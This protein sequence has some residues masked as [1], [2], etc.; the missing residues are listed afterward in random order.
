MRIQRKQRKQ[1][2]NDRVFSA[3]NDAQPDRREAVENELRLPYQERIRLKKFSSTEE[4]KES[5]GRDEFSVWDFE[6]WHN[7]WQVYGS[8]EFDE[9]EMH[10]C[11]LCSRNKMER[12]FCELAD[13]FRIFYYGMNAKRNG[14]GVVV[15][16]ELKRSVLSIERKSDRM[17]WV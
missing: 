4:E 11:A 14:V 3:V 5:A 12:W 13:G 1:T 7:D 8:G 9:K 15:D 2:N 16:P 17:I 6:C 10:K